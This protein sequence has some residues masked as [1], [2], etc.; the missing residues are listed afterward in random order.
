[1]AEV[2]AVFQLLRFFQKPEQLEDDHGTLRDMP[3][4]TAC[5][6]GHFRLLRRRSGSGLALEYAPFLLPNAASIFNKNS[7]SLRPSNPPRL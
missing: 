1:M 3:R 6:E 2:V 4:Y 7:P 5:L